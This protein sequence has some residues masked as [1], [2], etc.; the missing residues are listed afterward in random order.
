MT[1]DRA[2]TVC[3]FLV[4]TMELEVPITVA[5][6]AAVPEHRLDYAPDPKSKTALQLL[7]HLTLEDEWFLKSIADGNFGQMPDESAAC[8]IMTPEDAVTEYNRRIPAALKRLAA[9]DGDTLAK[10]MDFFGF[11]KMP[12]AGFMGLT[13]RHSIHHRGQLSAYLRAMGAKVPGIYGPSAD[14]MVAV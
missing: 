14:S 3:D 9:L 13:L 6:F 4:S 10:E 5:V 8:G 7:R 2:K 1:P 12:A 11:M